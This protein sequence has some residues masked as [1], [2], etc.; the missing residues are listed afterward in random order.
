MTKKEIDRAIQ[1]G[2]N[3]SYS[4][5]SVSKF[6]VFLSLKPILKGK[7]YWYALKEAYIMSDNLY[8]Y[9]EDIRKS[10]LSQEPNRE[11]IMNKKERAIYESLPE[12]VK[13][14][15]GMTVDEKS[16]GVFGVSWS[17][18]IKVAKYFAEKYRLNFATDKI[19]K[20]VHE[21]TIKKNEI[22]FLCNE[23]KEKEI[24]Y[25]NGK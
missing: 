1:F 11:Y 4:V 13:I 21:L 6:Q 14:Y 15:R 20:V 25:V 18:D 5:S 10:F 8:D 17:L 22:I 7:L 3:C 12:L 9:S 23:R 16:S 2:S 24:F 19:P